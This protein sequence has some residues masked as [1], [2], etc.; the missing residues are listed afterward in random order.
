MI[1]KNTFFI[2][3]FAV[4]YLL[5]AVVMTGDYFCKKL[6]SNYNRN[7]NI[8][9]EETVPEQE[10]YTTETQETLI[11]STEYTSETLEESTGEER[12]LEFQTVD[13]SYFDDAL[14]IGDSRME[15]IMEYSGLQ[16]ARF[17]ADSGMSVFSLDLKKVEVPE[18]GKVTFDEMLTREQYGKIYL[19]LGMNELGYKFEAIQKKYQ[20]TIE[21]IRAAQENA[22]IYLCANMHVTMEQSLKEQIYNNEN[23]NRVNEMIAGYADGETLF[24][25]DV[26]EL[27]DDETGSLSEEYSSDAFHVLG[28]YYVDWADWL[29]TKAIVKAE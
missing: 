6:E 2:S 12:P 28:K 20:E 24:Y 1:E 11:E 19:M 23:V 5:S 10:E 3:L 26:N 4:G 7:H 15:G 16:N 21:K 8:V 25:I 18:A 22:V 9:Q 13:Y 27:F 29:C 17:F 14:F